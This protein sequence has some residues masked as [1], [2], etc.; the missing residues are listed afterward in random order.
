VTSAPEEGPTVNELIVAY[1]EHAERYYR[2]PSGEASYELEN[3]RKALRRL[4]RLYGDTPAS[5]FDSLALESLRGR[6]IEDGL[7][8]KRINKDVDRIRRAFRWATSKLMVPLEVYQLLRT[9]EGLRAGRTDAKDL[10]PVRPVLDEHVNV[11]LPYMRPQV[12]AMVRS[13]G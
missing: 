1:W 4:R 9:I 10:P 6:M 13:K 12:A 11:T 7:C 3:I 8:R 5:L 2:K